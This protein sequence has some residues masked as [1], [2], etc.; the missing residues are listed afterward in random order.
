MDSLFGP[1]QL[2]ASKLSFSKKFLLIFIAAIVP[3]LVFL[4][5]ATQHSQAEILRDEEEIAGARYLLSVSPLA[6]AIRLHRGLVRRAQAGDAVAKSAIPAAASKVDALLQTLMAQKTFHQAEQW[7]DK[8]ERLAKDW[9]S[10]RGNWS[11]LS[12]NAA[13]NAHSAVVSQLN[14]YRHHVAG[15][16]GLL[17][18]PESAAYYQVVILFDDLPLL[19]DQLSKVRG[20]VS[21]GA[22]AS[23]DQAEAFAR[24]DMLVNDLLPH[25]LARINNN[26]QL[27]K[28]DYPDKAKLL[29]GQW[30]TIEKAIEQLNA[31]VN[32]E[33]LSQPGKPYDGKA[34]FSQASQ[35]IDQVD[36]IE[37]FITEQG[38]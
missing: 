16:T 9:A 34:F 18:D 26:L 19:E 27:L 14:E 10:V 6:D 13:F 11:T 28:D 1:F 24:T 20:L 29:L 35:I 22:T 21:A 33:V 12:A 31:M 5:L 3:G 8:M 7:Q 15:D 23:A 30:E 38:V 2:L 36:G 37:R 25:S 17:L 32:R 4:I